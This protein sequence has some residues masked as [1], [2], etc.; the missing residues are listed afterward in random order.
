MPSPRSSRRNATGFRPRARKLGAVRRSQLVTTYGVGAMIAIENESYIVAG[1]DSWNVDEAPEIL[2][3][4]LA[5]ALGVSSFRLPP[6]PDPE[7]GVDGVRVRRFPELYSCPRCGLLQRFSDFGVQQGRARC[8]K[9]VEDLVPSRFVLACDDGHIEDFPYW[10][11]LHRGQ[12]R[13]AGTCNGEL[14]LRVDGSSASLRSVVVGCSCKVPEVSMEGA[15]RVRA[16]IELGIR[17]NGKRPWLRGAKPEH[18]TRNPRTM[19][20]GSSSAWHPVMR[21]ALSIP[22]WGEGLTALIEKERLFAAT[23]EIVRYHFD[24]RPNLLRRLD[25]TVD[26][27]LAQLQMLRDANDA[28]VASAPEA[29]AELRKEEY[30]RLCR[31]N[32]ERHAADQQPFVCEKPDGDLRPL[33]EFGL[34]GSML[35]KRLREVR[36]LEGFTRGVP[37]LEA[38]PDQRL[39]ALHQSA[40]IDW[41]PAIEVNG[42]GVFLRLDEERLR[43]WESKSKVVDRLETMR[44][45]HLALLRERVPE[46]SGRVAASPVSPRF[47]LL[48]TLAHVLINEWSLDGGYPASALRERLY[49]TD[50][51]AGILIYTA[52]S[53]SA[54]SLGGIV[55]Q[56]DPERLVATMESALGRTSWCSNDPLC[57]ESEASGVD[58]VNMAACHAC[59]L[60]PETSCELNN[61]FMDRA[62][63]V[64]SQSGDVPGFFRSF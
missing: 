13:P 27:V 22:P 35:V 7:R 8:P 34:A 23:E 44:A 46:G 59:V 63:L 50:R 33:R 12:D 55:A 1:L 30:D 28:P 31:G 37:P 54:G 6:T 9:C 53:D 21:S 45:N 20:R 41:R 60:L 19:Q 64:G 39:A 15:F 57:M 17:C 49:A 43:E 25:A 26:D 18:C 11:W 42:E 51:M 29:Y 36:A 40:E 47:V 4:R 61:S 3:R 56:G 2:E 5:R 10:K 24:Q 48:H 58:S 32:P 52:T 16:L 38:A 14:Y 62:M